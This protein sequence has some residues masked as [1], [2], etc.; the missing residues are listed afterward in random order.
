MVPSPLP[1]VVSPAPDQSSPAKFTT[2]HELVLSIAC[3]DPRP[4]AAP[5]PWLSWRELLGER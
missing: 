5:H 3:A 4:L 2:T 1:V